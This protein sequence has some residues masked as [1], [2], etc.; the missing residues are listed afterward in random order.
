MRSWVVVCAV[1]LLF[2]GCEKDRAGGAGQ[3]GVVRLGYFTNVTHAQALVGHREGQFA[4]ALGATRLDVKQFNAGPT[5]MEALISGSL[6]MSYVGTGPAINTF[7]KAGKELR[8][9]AGAVNGG[10]S[11]VTKTAKT[12]QE[13]KGKKIAS[14]QLGN[15]QD[16]ALRHWLKMRGLT[17]SESGS[18]DVTI[19]PIQNADILALF[20]RGALEGAWVPEPWASRLVLEG[21]GQVLLDE[22]ELWPDK[23]FATTVLVTT[24]KF[25]ETRRQDVDAVLRAHVALTQEWSANPEA[26]SKRVNEAFSAA[27][28]KPLPDAVI[29]EA[30]KRI[31]PAAEPPV[32]AI[33]E[34]AKHANDLGFV[35]SANIEGIIDEQPLRKVTGPKTDAVPGG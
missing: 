35:P 27:V 10:A 19:T 16:I 18:A 29:T 9:I 11:L 21:G 17:F 26:F 13:L 32:N 30:F 7:L 24:R 31:E 1:A 8:I 15:S 4:K 2:A 3:A 25:L 6:D 28:G 22:R 34:A 33:T 5:A 23:K 12:P 14:P 20:Q